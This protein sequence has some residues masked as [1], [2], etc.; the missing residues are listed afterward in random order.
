MIS[1]YIKYT[2]SAFLISIG[3]AVT[4]GTSSLLL[5]DSGASARFGFT[6][7]LVLLG[8]AP[9]V[10]GIVMLAQARKEGRRVRDNKLQAQLMRLAAQKS[11]KLTL[12][13]VAMYLQIPIEEAEK[14]L[15][16]MQSKGIFDLQLTE[17]GAMVYRL[18]DYASPEEKYRARQVI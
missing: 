9:L 16:F 12:G 5:W 15:A 6:V 18:I 4:A 17:R 11:G 2:L 1:V 14:K 7:S 10:T 13:E 3:A 8:I